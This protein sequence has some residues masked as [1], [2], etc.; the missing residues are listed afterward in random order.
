MYISAS[1]KV[2]CI[3][4][5]VWTGSR[6]APRRLLVKD[7]FQ[8]PTWFTTQRRRTDAEYSVMSTG[9]FHL[10]NTEDGVLAFMEYSGGF[11]GILKQD[12]DSTLEISVQGALIVGPPEIVAQVADAIP[13]T[14]VFSLKDEN[15]ELS[16]HLD[17]VKRRGQLHR[18]D[19]DVLQPGAWTDAYDIISEKL[20]IQV[21][22][23]PF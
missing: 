14:I 22:S 21:Q 3:T 13:K 12:L 8:R 20:G 16:S 9:E 5:S 6:R 2:V 4:G 15:M 11:V 10:H 18:L 7:G 17:D 23:D 19:V 1:K